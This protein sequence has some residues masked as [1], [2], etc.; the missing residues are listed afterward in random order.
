LNEI[1]TFE[2]TSEEDAYRVL[3]I[4]R[5]GSFPKGSDIKFVGWPK[6]EIRYV[7]E[8]FNSTI[9]PSMMKGFIDFQSA[10]YRSY[11]LARYNSLNINKLSVEERKSLELQIRVDEG[12]SLFGIDFQEALEKIMLNVGGKMDSEQ[13]LVLGI[14]IATGYFGN[15]AY[16]LYL[17]S[18][19]SIRSEE[20][21]T[22]EQRESLRLIESISTEE[23]K[24][25]GIMADIVKKYPQAQNVESYAYDAKNSLVKTFKSAESVSFQGVVV[26]GGAAEELVKNSR[27]KSREI[28][29]DGGYRIL[30][31]DTTQK[32]GFKVKVKNTRTHEEFSAVVHDETFEQKYRGLIQE[33]EWSKKPVFLMISAKEIGDEVRHAEVLSAKIIEEE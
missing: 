6:L 33:A 21:K 19:K 22:E 11:A 8:G 18:R 15:T 30:L 26:S 25:A 23:T 4:F 5:S 1:T 10:I 16:K 31:V 17:D 12:S 27:R 3:E 13:I 28:R 29:L 32:D 24:R 20:L 14:V 9:T 7:G 2:I